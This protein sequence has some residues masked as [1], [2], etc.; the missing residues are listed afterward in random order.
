MVLLL[1]YC[2]HR[3][4]EDARSWRWMNGRAMMPVARVSPISHVRLEE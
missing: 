1:S 2:P 4:L 3:A